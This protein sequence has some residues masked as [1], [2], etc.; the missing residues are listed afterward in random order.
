MGIRSKKFQKPL[1]LAL[2][3]NHVNSQISLFFLIL[4]QKYPKFSELK[5]YFGLPHHYQI[6]KTAST[7][8]YI[9]PNYK[10]LSPFH[11]R[12]SRESSEIEALRI[13]R[14]SE[15]ID[16]PQIKI[17]GTWGGI[18]DDGFTKNEADVIC[19]QLG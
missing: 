16:I 2:E 9:T 5:K 13:Q 6:K 19:K 12:L 17:N 8:S 7:R 4:A 18:C 10:I 3:A 15:N 1:I 14:S 11:H